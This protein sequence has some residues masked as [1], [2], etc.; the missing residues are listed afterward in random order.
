MYNIL[1]ISLEGMPLVLQI[2]LE[3]LLFFLNWPQTRIL[4]G[5]MSEKNGVHTVPNTFICSFIT[6]FEGDEEKTDH[7]LDKTLAEMTK[8]YK[9]NIFVSWILSWL[10]YLTTSPVCFFLNLF[11]FALT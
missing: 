11:Y 4:L 10:I 3:F 5:I 1:L 8:R 6:C 2:R 9:N 7:P